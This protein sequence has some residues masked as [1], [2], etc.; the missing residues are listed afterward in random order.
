MKRTVMPPGAG[1]IG[2]VKS[3]RAVIIVHLL[4]G[5]KVPCPAEIPGTHQENTVVFAGFHLGEPILFYVG[6]LLT[7]QIVTV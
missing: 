4:D 6:V 5:N 1:R 2:H 7:V 3:I